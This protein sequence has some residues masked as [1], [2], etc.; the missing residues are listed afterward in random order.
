MECSLNCLN[1]LTILHAVFTM[2]C[3][4]NLTA[5]ISD[6][7]FQENDNYTFHRKDRTSFISSISSGFNHECVFASLLGSNKLCFYTKLLLLMKAIVM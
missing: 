1:P 2:L 4:T 7:E 5:D 6:A 3:V